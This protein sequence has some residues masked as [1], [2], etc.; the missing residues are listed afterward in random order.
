MTETEKYCQHSL[1]PVS[2][3]Q[4]VSSIVQYQTDKSMHTQTDTMTLTNDLHVC[5]LFPCAQFFCNSGTSYLYDL[6][7]LELPIHKF[8]P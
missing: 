8:H 3:P 7:T 1:P 2:E 6:T 4:H 5:R